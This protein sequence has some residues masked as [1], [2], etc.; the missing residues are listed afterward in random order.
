VTDK[1]SASECIQ[2]NQILRKIARHCV[3][4][5]DGLFITLPEDDLDYQKNFLAACAEAGIPAQALD[6][7]EAKRLEPAVNPSLIGAVRVP[8][9]VVDPFRLTVANALDAVERGARCHTYHEV[10]G[11]IRRNDA[12]IG[13][14]AFDKLTGDQY[15]VRAK[16]VVNA[17][18]IWGGFIAEM[19]G[20]ELKMFPTRGSLLIMGHRLTQMVIN[21]CR[22][23][24][25][26]DI[27]VPGD[28]VCLI[29]TTSIPI[30]FSDLDTTRVSHKEVDILIREGSLLCPSLAETR[31]I[32]CYAGS[33]P[34]IADESD[35]TGRAI[36]RHIVLLDHEKRDGLKGLITISGGKLITY[37]L[38]AEMTANLIGEK[39]GSKATCDTAQTP[40]P[41]SREAPEKT[42]RKIAPLPLTQGAA[43]I[44]RHGDMAP[45]IS[46]FD[47]GENSLACE[48]EL[49]S[50]GEI[51]HAVNSLAV[52]NLTDLR[53]RTRVGMGP[54]QGELCVGRATGLLAASGAFPP[55]EA[56]SEL[57]SFLEERW[58]GI[59]P[60][61]WGETLR[62]SEF[63]MWLYQCV[64]GLKESDASQKTTP[65]D[66]LKAA[67]DLGAADK[68]TQA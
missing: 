35:L 7:E 58:K 1:I 20:V 48:C 19:A 67:P 66:P 22:K 46:A 33:R 62:E 38:M 12:I 10:V 13:V 24:A 27:L 15:E 17:A 49:V 32:R 57:A 26:A 4:E 23:P 50:V 44:S 34:L 29:G 6:P 41:G 37:R 9:G 31:K 45:G 21:R 55:E 30:K 56:A 43:L 64:C 59:Y 40:L 42:L 25:D 60:L 11:L 3:E 61:A 18:G 39:L 2:E 28:T 51:Q 14:K 36:S 5:S 53:R 65:P 52:H 68:E 63:I 54:C 47:A 16:V 8:D